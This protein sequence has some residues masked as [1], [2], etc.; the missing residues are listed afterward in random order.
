MKQ[1]DGP[2]YVANRI[3]DVLYYNRVQRGP[4]NMPKLVHKDRLR[5]YRG[6]PVHIR[7]ATIVKDNHR[8]CPCS[9]QDKPPADDNRQV[10][11][12]AN[13]RRRRVVGQEYFHERLEEREVDLYDIVTKFQHV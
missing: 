11:L 13:S 2:Y 5:Q 1:W 6:V 10:N 12:G 3:N 8:R 4:R 9:G 7:W